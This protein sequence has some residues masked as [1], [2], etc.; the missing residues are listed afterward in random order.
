MLD[1]S[2]STPG[3]RRGLTNTRQSRP[4]RITKIE[5]KSRRNRRI[6]IALG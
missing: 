5:N 4:I 1:S 3:R 6:R 2:R